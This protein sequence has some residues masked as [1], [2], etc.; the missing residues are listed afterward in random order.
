MKDKEIT[1]A[2]MLEALKRIRKA[3]YLTAQLAAELRADCPVVNEPIKDMRPHLD[4]F[5]AELITS[6]RLVINS[7]KIACYLEFLAEQKDEEG[8]P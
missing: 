8:E 4:A 5:Q 1:P 6:M 7:I 3:L 2:E